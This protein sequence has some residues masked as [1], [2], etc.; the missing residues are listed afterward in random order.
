[1]IQILKSS[2]IDFKITCIMMVKCM[3]YVFYHY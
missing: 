2:D 1:M 3:L